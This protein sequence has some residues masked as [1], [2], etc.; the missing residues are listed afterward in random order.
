MTPLCKLITNIRELQEASIYF[1]AAG[2]NL[3]GIPEGYLEVIEQMLRLINIPEKQ[4]ELFWILSCPN[5]I[6]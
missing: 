2:E 6:N 1:E 3:H 5:K 4:R